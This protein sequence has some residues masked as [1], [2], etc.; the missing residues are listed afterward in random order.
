MEA[1][2]DGGEG[3]GVGHTCKKTWHSRPGMDLSR[4]FLSACVSVSEPDDGQ[5]CIPK[6]FLSDLNAAKQ[7]DKPLFPCN[8]F[9]LFFFLGEAGKDDKPKPP[10]SHSLTLSPCQSEG[11]FRYWWHISLNTSLLFLCFFFL[12]LIFLYDLQQIPICF[13]TSIYF[14][15]IFPVDLLRQEWVKVIERT[16][17]IRRMRMKRCIFIASLV[18]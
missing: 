1:G 14:S 3:E 10:H 11:Y 8:F 9:L 4:L 5:G 7:P 13:P 16:W 15:F 6:L 12:L 18:H 17:W 2:C